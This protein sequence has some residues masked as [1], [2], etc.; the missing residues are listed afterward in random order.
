MSKKK[1]KKKKGKK[2]K[3]KKKKKKK[4]RKKEDEGKRYRPASVRKNRILVLDKHLCGVCASLSAL[5][6]VTKEKTKDK[7]T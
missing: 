6:V 5:Q 7:S 1:K 4:K 2:E 3:R